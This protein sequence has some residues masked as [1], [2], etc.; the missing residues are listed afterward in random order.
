MPDFP[1]Q[2]DAAV[3]RAKA[4]KLLPRSLAAAVDAF[5]LAARPAIPRR[6]FCR[7]R[8]SRIDVSYG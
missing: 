8:H 4:A 5:N 6:H 7:A 2:D 3:G 1:H